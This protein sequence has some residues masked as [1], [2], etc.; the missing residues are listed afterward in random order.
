MSETIADTKLRLTTAVTE[1]NPEADLTS[2]GSVL[3]EL[4][5]KL[6]ANSQNPLVNQLLDLGQSNSISAVLNSTD[7][8]YNPIIDAIASNYSTTRS[9]G[10]KSV[11][12]LKVV[13]SSASNL[14]IRAGAVF[15]Q[16]VLKLNYVT[17][18]N[19]NISLNPGDG[20]LRLIANGR[21]WYFI[22]P[23]EAEAGGAEYQ[24]SDQ[25][26]LSSVSI[27]RNLVEIRSYGSFTSGQAVE[28]DKQLLARIQTSLVNKTLLTNTSISSRLYDTF[29]D[30]KDLSLVGANDEEMTRSKRNLFGISTLG[31]ADVYVRTAN[32]IETTSITKT[33]SKNSDGKW[34]VDLD[35]NDVAGFYRIIAITPVNS[36]LS[37]SLLFTQTFGLSTNNLSPVNNITDLYEARFTKYQTCN[38]LFDYQD[39]S[40]ATTA[41]FDFLI[42]YQPNI[43]DIQTL[44]LSPNEQIVCADYL[45]KAAIPCYVS[46][47]LKLHRRNASVELPVDKIK[48]DIFNYINNIR[49][50]EHL[51]VSNIIDICHNYDVKYVELPVTLTGEIYTNHS[52][53]ISIKDNDILRIPNR[54]DVGVSE[55]TTIFIT[56]YFRSEDDNRMSDAISITVY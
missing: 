50:G 40:G 37:G 41:D 53:L 38:V 4:V 56:D 32:G 6:A 13:V 21:L 28:T 30:F 26:P 9:Q 22:L 48:Q 14:F 44:F 5:I 46:V 39:P 25:S 2:P 31:M 15:T 24:L 33:V 10:K 20:E 27:I 18:Q 54:V 35:Y 55:K 11:G 1:T 3:S 47:D 29:P 51:Y 36:A 12:K 49:F 19:W 23:V 34:E 8:T 42:S 16:P 45:V 43:L 52:S 7:T 17:T